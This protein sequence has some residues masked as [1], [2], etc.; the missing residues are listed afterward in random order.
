MRP[1]RTS[2][3]LGRVPGAAIGSRPAPLASSCVNV[4]SYR[5]CVLRQDA[6]PHWAGSMV[7]EGKRSTRLAV[8]HLLA[9]ACG[10]LRIGG[11]WWPVVTNVTPGDRIVEEGIDVTVGV[12]K[13]FSFPRCDAS[14]I[15]GSQLAPMSAFETLL[16][17]I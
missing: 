10:R 16:G 7:G 2:Y 14:S 15:D 5:I 13:S 11:Q 1:V 4:H 3:A 8:E 17:S 6:A 9:H 12:K